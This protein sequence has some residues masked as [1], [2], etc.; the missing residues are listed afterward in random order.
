MN[1]D[2]TKEFIDPI[3]INITD[4]YLNEYLQTTRYNLLLFNDYNHQL[5]TLQNN[6]IVNDNKHLFQFIDTYKRDQLQYELKQ[7]ILKQRK[8]YQQ[9]IH[10]Y[11]TSIHKKSGSGSNI[12]TKDIDSV[13]NLIN[14]ETNF[15]SIR[16]KD[17]K[18]VENKREIK[19]QQNLLNSN[20]IIHKIIIFNKRKRKS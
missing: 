15:K 8:L 4:K 3:D 6:H 7:L 10:Y 19:L 2:F 12:G 16:S 14:I 13:S 18:E 1:I 20:S 17:L 5:Y 9:F 11:N